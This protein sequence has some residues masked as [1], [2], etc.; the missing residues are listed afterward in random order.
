MAPRFVLAGLLLLVAFGAWRMGLLEQISPARL[1]S[2][3]ARVDAAPVLAVFIYVVV[4]ALLT[5][6]CLPVALMM[7]LSGGVL[8]GAAVGGAATVVGAT[9][10]AV[11][12]YLAARTALAPS[13][14]ARAKRDPRMRKVMNGFGENAFSYILTMRLIPLFPFS[15]VNIAAGLAAAPI[16]AYAGATAV[17]A[18]PTSFIYASLGSGLGRSVNSEHAVAAAL[19][20]PAVLGSL[21]AL[22]LLSLA[23]LVVSRLRRRRP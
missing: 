18:V 17:G 16:R 19:H 12:T 15:L 2:L 3:Q 20:S 22:A 23:P 1:E 14:L 21:T 13:L 4:F 5:G 8:F 7:T 10:A 6:A 9:A 11:L